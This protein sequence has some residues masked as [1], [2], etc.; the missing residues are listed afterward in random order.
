MEEMVLQFITV[1][2]WKL[3]LL[4]CSGILLLGILKTFKVFDKIDESKRKYIYGAISTLF[5][6]IATCIYLVITKSFTWS[7]FGLISLATYF[8]NQSVY[9][10][11]ETY[12]LRAL[13]RRII[14]L[15]ISLF[16]KKKKD[17]DDLAGADELVGDNN[18]SDSELEIR[19][20]ETFDEEK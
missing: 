1:H 7:G 5:S 3:T 2:G 12:G 9:S 6:V 19:T 4:A 18:V 15:V 20:I 16:T 10:V 11:Y 17:V 13:V 8:L 14:S